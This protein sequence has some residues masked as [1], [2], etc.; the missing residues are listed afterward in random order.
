MAP[1]L[2]VFLSHFF[3]NRLF[4]LEQFS[5]YRKLDSSREFPYTLS[6]KPPVSPVNILHVTLAV[7]FVC[8]TFVIMDELVLIC[9]YDIK[10]TPVCISNCSWCCVFSVFG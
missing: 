5:V 1:A 7:T 3:L 2:S 6:P 8:A 9:H 10:A 4:F